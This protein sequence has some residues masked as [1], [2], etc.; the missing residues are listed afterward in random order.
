MDPPAREG[1]FGLG[2]TH[3]KWDALTVG[4]KYKLNT[5]EHAKAN[6]KSMNQYS[7]FYAKKK[8]AG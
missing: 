7:T 4:G 1:D 3:A 8:I 5:K 2:A 6:K